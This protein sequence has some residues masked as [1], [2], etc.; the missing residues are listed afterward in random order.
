MPKLPAFA[1]TGD[2]SEPAQPTQTFHESNFTVT[3][4]IDGASFASTIL[5]NSINNLLSTNSDV[6]VN[7]G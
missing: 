1:A 6:K 5:G 7:S 4:T 2:D 3:Q